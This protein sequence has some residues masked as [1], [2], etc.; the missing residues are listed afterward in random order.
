MITRI[1]S[2]PL[3]YK[4]ILPTWLISTFL[5]FI[6]GVTTIL[7]L[8]HYQKRALET[9][10]TI[11]TQGVANTLQAAMMFD[12]SLSAEEQLSNLSF[13]PDILAAVVNDVEVNELAKI[14]RLPK[15]CH[16]QFDSVRC[17]DIAFESQTQTI[18]LGEENLGEL[19]V[20]VSHER[21]ML[22][23]RQMWIVLFSTSLLLSLFAW[24]FAKV[25][26]SL[27]VMPLNSL[28]QSMQQV[29]EEG[30]RQRELPVNQN[31]EL[32]KLT[33]C[34]NV[35]VASLVDRERE[36]SKALEQLE[37]KNRYI[38]RALDVME[39]GILVVSP[40]LDV[41]YSN[42]FADNQ[43]QELKMSR[44]ARTLLESRFNPRAG[45]DNIVSA[46]THQ[47]V[48]ESVE[49]HQHHS[50]RRYRVSCH[51]LESEAHTLVQFEDFTDRYVS[52]QRRSLIELVF[53]Q[54]MDAMLVLDRHG[55]V[56]MMNSAAGNWFGSIQ[57]FT[58]IKL[59]SKDRLSRNDIKRLLVKERIENHIDIDLL[60]GKRIP[61]HVQ[62]RALKSQKGRVEA[63]LVTLRDLTHEQ[64]LQRLNY[65][66][67]HD[68]LTGLSNRTA[69]LQ[70]LKDKHMA[71]RDQWVLFID[72]D[73]FKAI[74]DKYGHATGD[75]LLR[76]VAN[77]LKEGAPAQSLVSRLS[78]DEFLIGL[79]ED[80]KLDVHLERLLYLL[81]TPIV[82]DGHHCHV[83]AS[84]GVVSWK[85]ESKTPL[86]LV[87]TAAD[88]AM[89]HAKRAGKNQYYL[90]E[91]V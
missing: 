66:V 42:P 38:I 75:E 59:Q 60:T 1:A 48:V 65:Q 56:S 24:R 37:G 30:I 55:M 57:S 77:R 25:M 87:V 13:D 22:E 12:D 27:I 45:I 52:E 51:P 4:M 82:I 35:M 89:Y 78:G 41:I 7:I 19:R 17:D 29:I 34:F 2:L 21:L 39:K 5:V 86:T 84:I 47:N 63:I 67:S 88:Q 74:N 68:V 50:D 54:N 58:E 40:S 18:R 80:G 31:D 26:H 70:I 36:L 32:G 76:I 49:L 44:D 8:T 53:E 33:T 81:K 43:I 90:A 23:Q 62:V 64:E 85:K 71:H 83:S 15:G 69:A 9:R 91:A 16:W 3:R 14:L 72:L 11:L 61:C 20:W 79:E 28:H 10:V 73:G 6:V 46:I